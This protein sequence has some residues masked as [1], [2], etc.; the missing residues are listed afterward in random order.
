[1]KLK[2]GDKVIVITGKDKNKQG[3]IVKT[4]KNEDKVIVEGINIATKHIK[5]SQG[6]DGSIIKKEMPI[7]ISN[8]MIVDPKT[9]KRTRLTSG[10]D[11]N[12]KKVRITK[13]SNS[14]LD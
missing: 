7:H 2:V 14:T 9:N 1:M 11:K 8:V 6:N 5:K 3:K 4:L 10:L 12:S 13:K